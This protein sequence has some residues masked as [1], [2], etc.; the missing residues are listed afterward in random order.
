MAKKSEKERNFKFKKPILDERTLV[1]LSAIA[2]GSNLGF[3]IDGQT[4]ATT[5]KLLKSDREVNLDSAVAALWGTYAESDEMYDMFIQ[6]CRWWLED[7]SNFNKG[8]SESADPA[9]IRK[10]WPDIADVMGFI[11]KRC[12]AAIDPKTATHRCEDCGQLC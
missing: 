6:E 7:K 12:N 1:V 4:K 5:I 9:Y 2:G 10:V 8:R 11:C 3:R